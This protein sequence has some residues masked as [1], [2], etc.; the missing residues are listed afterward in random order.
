MT[1]KQPSLTEFA[2]DMHEDC[3]GCVRKEAQHG[4]RFVVW[5]AKFEE[6]TER[7][8]LEAAA[9]RVDDFYNI[10]FSKSPGQNVI[11]QIKDAIR[12]LTISPEAQ[13]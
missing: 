10:Y 6:R 5:L 1:A 11:N 8:A 9:Q 2:L 7:E 3:C 12:A 4:A 13:P